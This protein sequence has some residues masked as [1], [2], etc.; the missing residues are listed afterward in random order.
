[1][2]SLTFLISRN[3]VECCFD[4]DSIWVAVEDVAISAGLP[5][6]GW[7]AP[8]SS[9]YGDAKR[10]RRMA[11][12]VVALHKYARAKMFGPGTICR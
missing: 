8:S 5:Y 6:H 9:W 2:F 11:L 1:M 3:I 4:V 7:V 10:V 12:I